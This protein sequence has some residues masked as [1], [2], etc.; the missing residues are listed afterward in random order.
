MLFS[1]P[2]VPKEEIKSK[3]KIECPVSVMHYWPFQAAFGFKQICTWAKR[4]QTGL[5]G[6]YNIGLILISPYLDKIAN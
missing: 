2:P 5:I 1:I 4:L 6:D 3:R